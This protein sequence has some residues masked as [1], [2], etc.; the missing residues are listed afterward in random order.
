LRGVYAP[1]YTA[2]NTFGDTIKD[3]D[4]K[5]TLVLV[6]DLQNDFCHEKS[7]LSRNRSR[8]RKCAL[9]IYKFVK[10]VKKQ[11]V[12]IAFTQQIYDKSKLTSR[13]KHYYKKYGNICCKRGSFGAKYYQYTP[14]KDK[15]FTKYNFDIW[16]NNK[17]IKFLD[18]NKIDTLIITGVEILC[19]V[20]Y[21]VLGADERG[22]NIVVP[23]DLV[24]GADGD[25]KKQKDLLN[26][27]GTLYGPVVSSKDILRILNKHY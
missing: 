15:L 26:I 1:C 10:E 23:K 2:L 11:G 19:C 3:I 16:Q 17:F 12:K 9:A 5:T 13:Q 24:S 8:N 14:P 21:A 27:M 25:A 18:K 7:V 6:I 22:F 20:L 4:P